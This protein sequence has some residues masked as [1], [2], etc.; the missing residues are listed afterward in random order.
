MSRKIS[1]VEKRGWLQEYESGLSEH[2]LHKK[3]NKDIRTIKDALENARLDRDY[4]AARVEMMKDVLLKH[5]GRLLERLHRYQATIS[6]PEA[7][8]AVLSW[9]Q[10]GGSVF[11]KES[12]PKNPIEPVDAITEMLQQ[13]LKNDKLWKLIKEWQEAY[14]SNITARESLQRKIFTRLKAIG[15]PVVDTTERG[16]PRLYI[17]T[18]GPLFYSGALLSTSSAPQEQEIVAKAENNAVMYRGNVLIG[19][20]TN[21]Q[22]ACLTLIKAYRRMSRWDEVQTV[23]TTQDALKK[24]TGDAQRA[25]EDVLLLD[26]IPGE[27]NVCQRMSRR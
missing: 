10:G 9:Y 12:T 1:M 8:L 13:H 4:S 19:S 17:N 2:S 11:S 15:Y 3:Y 7:D 27:C 18:V 21:L 20:P 25:I 5:Q 22:E 14:H 26:F 24:I 6:I 23:L 16:V